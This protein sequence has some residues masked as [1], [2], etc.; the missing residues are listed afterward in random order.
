MSQVK[1]GDKLICVDAIGYLKEGMVYTVS[2]TNGISGVKVKECV[3][4]QEHI[5]FKI[6]RFVPETVELN[7]YDFDLLRSLVK[8]IK[9]GVVDVQFLEVCDTYLDSVWPSCKKTV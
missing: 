6:E 9:G 7:F 8:D 5:H 3:N 4:S 2:S 1:V